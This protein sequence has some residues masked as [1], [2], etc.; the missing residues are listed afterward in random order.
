[1]KKYHVLISL[2]CAVF[3]LCGQTVA[4]RGKVQDEKGDPLSF[5]NVQ[6]LNAE[7][8]KSIGYAVTD[9]TGNFSVE[10]RPGKYVLKVS[11]IGYDGFEQIVDAGGGSTD[12][13]CCGETRTVEKYARRSRR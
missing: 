8:Q 11:F 1:M 12:F 6:L 13:R 3:S 5:A 9:S 10:A 2:F 7:N 4:I